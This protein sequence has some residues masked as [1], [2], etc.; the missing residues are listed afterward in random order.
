MKLQREDDF[1]RLLLVG[2]SSSEGNMA[3]LNDDT[4]STLSSGFLQS[5]QV[6]RQVELFEAE[7]LKW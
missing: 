4:L 3:V 5:S 7:L 2:L 1:T 6:N